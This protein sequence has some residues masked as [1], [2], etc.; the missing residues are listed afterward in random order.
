MLIIINIEVE[1]YMKLKKKK[2]KDKYLPLNLRKNGLK[3]VL[4]MHQ[5]FSLD[6]VYRA[7]TLHEIYLRHTVTL[8]K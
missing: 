6:V 7:V 4:G 3:T 8:V 1:F 5:G 2:K